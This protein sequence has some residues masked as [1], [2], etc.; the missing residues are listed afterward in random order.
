MRTVLLVG[1]V[2]C[3]AAAC[4]GHAVTAAERHATASEARTCVILLGNG[5]TVCSE[6]PPRPGFVAGALACPVGIEGPDCTAENAT[7]VVHMPVA[8]ETE[9]G[10]VGQVLA[11]SLSLAPGQRHKITCER[12]KG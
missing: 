3:A 1:F 10:H 11:T 7:D 2:G 6:A 12:R 4:L 5:R 9:C 8:H